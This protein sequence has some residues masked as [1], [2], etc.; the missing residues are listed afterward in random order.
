MRKL[1][2]R[3]TQTESKTSHFCRCTKNTC[4]GAGCPWLL[5]EEEAEIA[6]VLDGA[7]EEDILYFLC[8]G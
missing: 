6:E 1:A 8:H 5:E 2:A 4:C 7:E 3:A